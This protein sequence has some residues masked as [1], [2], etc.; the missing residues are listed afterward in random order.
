MII[1]RHKNHRLSII[2]LLSIILVITFSYFYLQELSANKLISLDFFHTDHN[3][4][5]NLKTLPRQMGLTEKLNLITQINTLYFSIDIS[6][7][8]GNYE[9]A[10]MQQSGNTYRI[11]LSNFSGEIRNMIVT[12]SL[13]GKIEHINPGRYQIQIINGNSPGSSE[14]INQATFQIR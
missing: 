5:Y 10:H 4:S 12:Y 11:Y 2:V 7:G 14:I 3:F 13:T 1:S 9:V 6:S 8:S